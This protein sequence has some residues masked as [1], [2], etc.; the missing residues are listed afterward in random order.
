[1]KG[2]DGEK[3]PEDKQISASFV[4]GAI[5]LVFLIIGYEAA[6]FVQKAAVSKVVAGRDSPDTVYVADPETV[7]SILGDD[8]SG[9]VDAPGGGTHSPREVI[10]RKSV[11][12]SR[13]AK[14]IASAPA[15]RR[16]VE[17]FRF[18][19]NTVS[20]ED[21]QR[22][23]FSEKQAQ[24]IDNYRIKGGRFRRREDFAKSYVV[25]DSV[26]ERLAPYIDIPK[27]DLNSADSAL[28]VTLPGIGGY[29]ASKIISYRERLGAYSYKEQLLDIYHFDKDKLNQIVD[30]VKVGPGKAFPLWSAS[31][32]ELKAHPYIASYRTARGIILY[33]DNHPAEECTV[34]GLV[35]AG[36]LSAES[37]DK[38]SR[39]RLQP[40]SAL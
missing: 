10:G 22:L 31:E 35:A 14:A 37:G 23:G 32:E 19:P 12:H 11:P 7:R 5:A 3:K 17:S 4:K 39:C 29:F 9:H 20:I 6:L 1:M 15:V 33:R 28:L 25:A 24:S 2:R 36:V 26:Y 16:K 8:S 13:E 30:L 18:D 38:L 27:I 21:L 40:P 34:E